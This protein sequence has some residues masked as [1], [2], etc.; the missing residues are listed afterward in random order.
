MDA[1]P[2]HQDN[3]E[4]SP[5][6]VHVPHAGQ[7]AVSSVLFSGVATSPCQVLLLLF[8]L[9]KWETADGLW[10]K[11]G[12]W[13]VQLHLSAD[14]HALEPVHTHSAPRR[15]LASI[16]HHAM[17]HLI[18]LPVLLAWSLSPAG[19]FTLFPRGR[20]APP[21]IDKPA[22]KPP[23]SEAAQDQD[24]QNL[25]PL[26]PW[27]HERWV[28]GW[29]PQSCIN[30]AAYTGF[31]AAGFEAVEVWYEDCA[32]S[33]TVCRHER[34]DESW[35]YILD[36]SAPWMQLSGEAKHL[37]HP[38]PQPSPRRPSAVHLGPRHRPASNL[39]VEETAQGA[40]LCICEA[41]D[42]RVDVYAL[43]CVAPPLP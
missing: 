22:V 43:A 32:A 21:V 1:F 31:D 17:H 36:V 7:V 33:W 37:C 29:L 20:L 9:G 38:D 6:L 18:L 23:F 8:R 40:A 14:T 15:G 35:F 16:V 2:P 25:L 28:P 12:P 39:L 26:V 13:H 42:W 34:A 41:Q 24:F 27:T 3:V 5:V 30:E 10:S 4:P 19:A 11:Q